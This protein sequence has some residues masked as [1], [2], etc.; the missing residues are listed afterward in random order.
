MVKENPPERCVYC[1]EPGDRFESEHVIAKS[2]YPSSKP[3]NVEL[4]KV[5]ACSTCNRTLGAA[6]T[7]VRERLGFMI[8]PWI[9]GGEGL[10]ERSFRAI[11]PSA[12]DDVREKERR[13]A[14]QERLGESLSLRR[15]IALKSTLP[16]VGRIEPDEEGFFLVSTLAEAALGKVI[17]KWVRGFAYYLE[18]RYLDDAYVVQAKEIGQ[19]NSFVLL[20]GWWAK[21]FRV[22]NGVIVERKISPEDPVLGLYVFTLW[23]RMKLLGGVVTKAFI[24]EKARQLSR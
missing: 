16:N 14:K 11:D 22:G 10:G 7:Y 24:L 1:L 20:G 4:P 23:G 17:K 12:A 9:E 3:Q 13:K 5:P 2:W 6:E 15:D 18:G 8:D 21:P 19:E